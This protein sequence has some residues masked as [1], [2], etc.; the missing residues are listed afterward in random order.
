ME[1]GQGSAFPY[2]IRHMRPTDIPALVEFFNENEK[3][4]KT[5]VAGSVPEFTEWYVSPSNHTLYT[6]AFAL[7]A[8]GSEGKLVGEM[9]FIRRGGEDQVMGWMHVHPGYRLNGVGR[10]LYAE[11][12]RLLAGEDVASVVFPPNA[13]ATLLIEFLR[14]RGFE[15]DRYFWTLQLPPDRLV[16]EAAMLEG[17]TVRTFRHG[18]DEELF[19]HVRNATFAGHYGSIPRTLEEMTYYTRQEHFRAEGVF[20]AFRGDDIA[21]FSY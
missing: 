9:E 19:A 18:A 7:N 15:F 11:F 21:G 5:V 2:I 13:K 1:S 12:E 3:L 8:D 10:A 4:E 16:D 6:L 17:I 20:F 14:R